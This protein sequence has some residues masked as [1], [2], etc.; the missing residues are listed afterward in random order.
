MNAPG[1]G[2]VAAAGEK[3]LG[4]AIVR[5]QHGD[6]RAFAAAYTLVQPSLLSY[7]Y[8]L[9]GSEAEDVASD[10]WL[11]IA[12]DLDRFSGNGAGFR[13]WAMSIARNRA[14][15]HLRRRR[16]RPRAALL[17]QDVYELPNGQD[18]AREALESISTQH[19]LALIALLPCSQAQAV[20]L[21]TVIGLDGVTVARILGRRPGAVRSAAHRGLHRLGRHLD[22]GGQTPA[23]RRDP[24]RERCSSTEPWGGCSTASAPQDAGT[25]STSGTAG[26]GGPGRRG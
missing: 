19:V 14:V 7:L 23:G 22:P 25:G 17:N 26:A 8:G 16:S 21:R 9:V 20:L 1:R 3:E 24:D 2:R 10:A 13:A 11:E 15:D 12:R 5:A 4:R 6:E 18:T